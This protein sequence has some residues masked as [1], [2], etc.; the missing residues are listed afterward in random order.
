MSSYN[1]H[2]RQSSNDW[3]EGVRFENRMR[4]IERDIEELQQRVWW[5][6]VSLGALGMLVMGL[7]FRR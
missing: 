4:K 2:E 6:Y 1:F 5:Y 7:F 3:Q